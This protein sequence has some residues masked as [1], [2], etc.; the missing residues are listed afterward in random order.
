VLLIAARSLL[1]VVAV[2]AQPALAAASNEA[3]ALY[4]QGR[5]AYR[6]D[7]YQRAMSILRPLAESGHAGAQYHVG[8]LYEKGQGVAKDPAA[9]LKWY[10][11][12]AEG[13]NARAQ[14]KLAIGYARGWPG[15][16]KNEAETGRWL[17]RAA[18]GGYWKA[19]AALAYGYRKGRF[20]FARDADSAAYWDAKSKQTRAE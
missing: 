1:L 4:E 14:Y 10:R 20:G 19:Q 3:Q 16:E 7:D 9:T 12:A 18:Y 15:L 6:D 2:L 5:R 11:L 8:R 13:G 17:L